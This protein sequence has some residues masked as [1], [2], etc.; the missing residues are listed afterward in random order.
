MLIYNPDRDIDMKNIQTK[1]NWNPSK[2]TQII[3]AFTG[4]VKNQLMSHIVYHYEVF[5]SDGMTTVRH[6][7]GRSKY[8]SVH[9]MGLKRICV[10]YKILSG[11]TSFPD[12]TDIMGLM[13]SNITKCV[14]LHVN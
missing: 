7:N 9:K 1:F 8:T 11:D 14:P 12:H 6:T 13:K 10:L 4:Q 3:I 2:M 5:T